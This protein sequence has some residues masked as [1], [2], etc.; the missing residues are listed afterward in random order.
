MSYR[1]FKQL[2]GENNL[3]RK[4]R[5][6]LGTGILVLMSLSFW[7]YAHQTA[8]LAYDQTQMTGQLLVPSMTRPLLLCSCM[9]MPTVRLPSSVIFFNSPS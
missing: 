6:L 8:E 9:R 4:C 1:S 5:L 3:E 7:L 2:L